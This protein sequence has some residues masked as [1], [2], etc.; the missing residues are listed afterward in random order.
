MKKFLCV[1]LALAMVS[2][3]FVAAVTMA[4]AG[5]TNVGKVE[6]GYTPVEGSIA[7]STPEEFAAMEAGKNYH[8]TADITV[9]KTW[10]AGADV[11]ASTGNTAF[12]GIFDGNGHTVTVSVPLFANG[13]GAT[14]KNLTIA[15]NIVDFPLYGAALVMHTTGKLTVENVYNKASV[16]S[17]TYAAAILAEGTTAADVT[18][19]NCINE[20][21]MTSGKNTFGGFVG[22]ISTGTLNVENCINV[23]A[24]KATNSYGGGIVGR[25]GSNDAGTDCVCVIKNCSNYGTVNATGSQAGG[26]IGYGL[27]IITIENCVNYETA[28]VTNASGTS[29]GIAGIIGHKDKKNLHGLTLKNCA[30]YAD[31]YGTAISA[32]IA[33]RAGRAAS[34]SGHIYSVENCEN[35][36]DVY[37]NVNNPTSAVTVYA[38]GITGY[39]WGGAGCKTENNVNTGD[40]IVNNPENPGAAV[41]LHIAGHLAYV[42][43]AS[44]IIANNINVGEIKLTGP[45]AT[46]SVLTSYNKNADSASKFT[47]NYST[48]SGSVAIGQIGSTTALEETSAKLVT[49]EQVKSGE[50]AYMAN[51]GA[52][53]EIFFQNLKEDLNPTV[54][55]AEDGSNKVVLKDGAYVN[56]EKE[57][58]V[59]EPTP[60]VTEPTPDVTE[61]TPDVT[62]PTPDVTEPT[63]DVTEPTPD[64]TEPTPDVTEPTPD[65]TEPT[66]DVT[67][68]EATEP[69]A[70]EPETTTAE[71]DEPIVGDSIGTVLVVAVAAFVALA[72]AVAM[73]VIKKR[74]NN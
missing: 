22:Y 72:G 47:N 67:E 17:A 33:G 56:P 49:A 45:A 23:G 61:P 2:T 48:A 41:T 64:V 24:L 43:G 5:G 38:G 13:T 44:Y 6:E 54:F 59:T 8:L 42:S 52:G 55:A 63:P 32:G 69:E 50:V 19:K 21:N 51:Q 36:G 3:M 39:A 60:D 26:I 20:G 73:I 46:T 35:H 10:N 40:I 18:I 7:V 27:G 70:T 9:N 74:E 66:P 37:L 31:V 28:T 14:I 11:A 12:A 1:L 68:P 65:V 62:E 57:P 15:G 58:E 4:S 29:G 30:N 25:F 71:S 34:A 16:S 53:E